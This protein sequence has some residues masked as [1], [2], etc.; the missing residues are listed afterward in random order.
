MTKFFAAVGYVASVLA[1]AFGVIYLINKFTG[2][3]IEDELECEC[4][5]CCDGDCDEGNT[6]SEDCTCGKTAEEAAAE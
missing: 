6:C 2:Y 3:E 5:D 4:E 1:A